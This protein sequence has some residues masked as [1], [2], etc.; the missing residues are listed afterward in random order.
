MA[1]NLYR[2]CVE[3]QSPE[4]V[5]RFVRALERQIHNQLPSNR[6]EE[7]SLDSQSYQALEARCTQEMGEFLYAHGVR[8]IALQTEQKICDAVSA[9]KKQVRQI[10]QKT[11]ACLR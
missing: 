10:I 9:S 3:T 4:I 5:G 8:Q 11:G 6:V 1:N 2:F 7:F